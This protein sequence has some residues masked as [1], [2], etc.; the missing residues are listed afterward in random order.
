MHPDTPVVVFLRG[1]VLNLPELAA[2]P[3]IDAVGIDHTV[4]PAW[5]AKEI[6]PRAAVQGN[7]DPVLLLVGGSELGR[8]AREIVA[9][10]SAGAHVFNLGHGI[11]PRTPVEHVQFLV[12]LI[13]S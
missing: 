3:E 8:G 5:A 9:S 13:R 1:S 4:N 6:Q 10:L 7:L 11:L 2:A 12:D